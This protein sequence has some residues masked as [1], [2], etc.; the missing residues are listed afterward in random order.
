MDGRGSLP[1]ASLPGSCVPNPAAV[2]ISMAGSSSL[3]RPPALLLR[4]AAAAA[5]AASAA[6]RYPRTPKCA[7]CRNHGVVSALKGHKRFCRWRDCMC[8]KCMLIAER[9]RV[10]AAQVALRRQQAQEENEARELQFMYAG[11]GA[12]EAGLA[13]A[14]AAAAANSIIPGSRAV[15]TPYEMFGAEYHNQKDGQKSPKYELFYNGLVSR[16]MLQPSHSLAPETEGSDTNLRDKAGNAEASENESAQLSLSPDPP[17]EGA[18]SPR[19]MSPS[20]GESG[21]ECEKPKELAKVMANLPGSSSNHRAPIDILTKVFPSHKRDK[22]E[23]I[24]AGCKGNVVQA[25]EQVLNGKEAKAQVK[26]VQ[27]TAPEP[28]ELQRHSHFTLAGLSGGSLGTKS[29]FSPLQSSAVF[30]GPANLYG[31]NPRLGVNPLRLAYS[32]PGRG[33]PT[34]MSP[35]VTSGLMPT[36]PFRPQIDYSFPGI[37]RDIPYFQNKEALCSGGLYSRI[38]PEKQ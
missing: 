38:N 5:A 17:S 31:L 9:Q 21:N 14:A 36:L 28:G 20:D 26:D 2:P 8:A 34:F 11:G 22:L 18:D 7:R 6:E 16:S 13:M 29:A 33:L 15:S 10:M 23:C 19:S 1:S 35:Y 3:L 27:C 4:A 24:L 25:I 12:A 30:G 37:V 32:N